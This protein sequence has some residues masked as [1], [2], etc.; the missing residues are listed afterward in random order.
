MGTVLFG[1]ESEWLRAKNLWLG[2]EAKQ[3]REG[4]CSELVDT[5]S[6]MFGRLLPLLLTGFTPNVRHSAVTARGKPQCNSTENELTNK[7]KKK[8]DKGKRPHFNQL[9][10]RQHLI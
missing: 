1:Q 3:S 7:Q 10:S 2:S 5:I 9:D 6:S 8:K 4:L